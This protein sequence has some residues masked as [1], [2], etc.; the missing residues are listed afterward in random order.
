MVRHLL[1]HLFTHPMALFSRFV[2]IER[3]CDPVTKQGRGARWHLH[4]VHLSLSWRLDR[5][6]DEPTTF[7]PNDLPMAWLRV[8][9]TMGINAV[10]IIELVRH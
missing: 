9:V 4:D 8:D 2:R 10:L 6:L 1:A 3:G 7:R 5:L